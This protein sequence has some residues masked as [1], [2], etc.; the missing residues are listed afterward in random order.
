MQKFELLKHLAKF[1]AK[2]NA[3]NIILFTLTCLFIISLSTFAK[4][5]GNSPAKIYAQAYIQANTQAIKPSANQTQQLLQQGETLYQKGNFDDAINVLQQAVSNYKK[6]NNNLGQ[7]A[8]LTNLSLV[9]QQLG[10]QK[11]ADT[12]VRDSLELL[13]WDSSSQKLNIKN[14]NSELREVLAQTLDI[15]AGLLLTEGKPDESLQI[16]EQAEKIWDELKNDS[17]A[18]RSR[19]N[20]AQALRVSGFYGRSRGILEELEKQLESPQ[21]DP[22]VKVTALRALGNTRQQ[23]GDLQKSEEALT[24]SLNIRDPKLPQ[25]EI[26]LTEFSLGNTY[27][28]LNETKEAI[29]FYTSAA[30]STSNRLTKVQAQINKLS[31]LVKDEEEEE[32]ENEQKEEQKITEA[33]KLLITEGKTLIPTIQSQLASL[34]TNQVGIYARINFARTLNTIDNKPDIAQALGINAENITQI[35]ATTL[36]QARTVGDERAQS[37]ALGILGEVYE[38]KSRWE[39]AQDLTEQALFFAQK[40]NDLDVA[41]IWEWQLGRLLKAQDDIPGAISAYD[42]AVGTLASIRTDLAKV[43]REAQFNFRDRVEPIY[44]ESVKLLLQEQGKGENK[45]DLLDKVRKRM[46]ALQVAELDN[47]FREACLSNEFVVIDKVVDEE[48]P[49]TAIL[50]PIILDDRLEI[51]LK[52]PGQELIRG[53]SPPVKN[54]EVERI[55]R[56]MRDIIVQPDEQDEFRADS[57][58]LYQWLIAPI[59]NQLQNSKVTNLLFIPDGSLRN[60]PMAALYDGKKYLAQRYAIAISPG[61][62]LF[63]PGSLT[64]QQL[65][66]L[67]GGLSEIPEEFKDENFA[68]LENVS[69]ELDSIEEAGLTTV[70]LYNNDFTSENLQNKINDDPF[71]IV[72]LATHG[73][74]SSRAEETFILAHDKRINVAQLDDLL[75]SRQERRTEPIELLV[76]SA[77]Q[78]ATGDDRA[79]LGLAGVALRAGARSTLASLWQIGDAPTADFIDEFYR[80]LTTNKNITTAQALR[81]SQIKLMKL[82]GYENPMF[83]AP[84]VLVGNWL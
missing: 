21:I 9:Y 57:Q 75:R 27:R 74:F 7:A 28:S 54:T 18:M 1:T 77:C 73:K 4:N 32:Q 52:L 25:E 8:A 20:Q 61:L 34:P 63:I 47:Y 79:A 51:I 69:K 3:K 83:W 29:K 46:E 62:Q 26:A 43:N 5:P 82:P 30:E 17:G 64:R 12:A 22:L 49:D 14:P 44:R 23:L 39:E 2:K 31:L 42:S 6:E 45:P 38:N 53:T 76:L 40:N 80:Q 84:Y 71:Q 68:P 70:R 66:V 13:G 15:Q 48:N 36:Q 11:E 59:E 60:I 37:Y 16:S 81:A 58:R 78:T 10:A 55:I 56:H 24:K 65:N 72:H 50:Y 35:L 19:I 33:K 67:A 41:Y